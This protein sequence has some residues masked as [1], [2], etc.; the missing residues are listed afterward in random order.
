MNRIKPTEVFIKRNRTCSAGFTLIELLVVIAIIAILAAMLLPALAKAKQKAQGIGC[1]SNMKQLC[2]G[3]K[4][5]SGDNQDRL[6]QNGDENDQ[7]ASLT[8]PSAQNGGKES[9]WCPGGQYEIIDHIT[10]QPQL[11]PASVTAANN[12]GWQWI[13]LGQIY[14]YVNNVSL[15]HCPADNTSVA[16]P[17]SCPRVRSM[18]MNAWMN[19]IAVWGGDTTASNT[20]VVYRKESD[21]NRPGPANLWVFLDENPT[22]IN[23]G[24]FI[25][26]P[27]LAFQ[28]W[29]D[30]PA[31]Y[32]NNAGGIAFADGHAEIHKWN[33]PHV[34][35]P[36]SSGGQNTFFLEPTNP[37][38]DLQF[39]RA[40]SSA[41]R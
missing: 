11:S 19:P 7:P 31:T 27:D 2:L 12:V 3:W 13:K 25:S 9:Q 30:Y 28:E 40:A 20:L 33:D 22:S 36:A 15:Y 35:K 34:L 14:P 5:Y 38:L 10:G 37:S 17:P 29:I 24:S 39:L 26:D 6:T 16:G 41:L 18:S 4:M 32:H 23:D 1:M 21:M 8:D